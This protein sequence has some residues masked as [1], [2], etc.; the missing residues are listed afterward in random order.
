M[1]HRVTADMACPEFD[2]AAVV[3][4][5]EDPDLRDVD[6][7]RG[8]PPEVGL[9]YKTITTGKYEDN[10]VQQSP[11][12]V[13]VIEVHELDN[14][15]Y[16]SCVEEI[17][18]DLISENR[19]QE[20][21]HATKKQAWQLDRAPTSTDWKDFLDVA[22]NRTNHPQLAADSTELSDEYPPDPSVIEESAWAAVAG[23]IQDMSQ[24]DIA[25][26]ITELLLTWDFD[27][28]RQVN[29]QPNIDIVAS[30]PDDPDSP[31]LKAF[32]DEEGDRLDETY[33]RKF[34]G[35]IGE[36]ENGLIVTP[37]EYSQSDKGLV[38][39]WVSEKDKNIWCFDLPIFVEAI[40]TYYSDIGKSGQSKI[41]L[42]QV[43]IPYPHQF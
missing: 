20:I 9:V 32:I 31:S 8:E 26:V 37:H 2:Y 42:K 23:V 40:I 10:M 28:I 14:G 25:E 19:F 17:E 6:F 7:F 11:Q 27:S 35:C 13:K 30:N 1:I 16:P 29:G 15:T 41:P 4:A 22:T 43:Y 21:E 3:E 34:S 36:E 5:T 33:L 12:Q 38:H 39:E 24:E 18:T